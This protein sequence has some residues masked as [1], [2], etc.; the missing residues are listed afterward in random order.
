[1]F[2]LLSLTVTDKDFFRLE[3]QH[4]AVEGRSR[5]GHETY[6][7]VR[8]LGIGLDVGRG[9]D[10]LVPMQHLFV[11]HAHLDHAA[12]IAFWAAQRRLQQLGGG[13]V[14]VPSEAAP[15]FRELLRLQEKLT[16]S[17][18]DVTVV[19]LAAGEELR[20][21]SRHVVRA[22][23][24][25]HRVAARAWEIVEVRHHLLPQYCGLAPAE[26]A[27]LRRHGV[28]VDEEYRRA[29]LFYT[30][31][32]D[33]GLLEQCDEAFRSE[34][35]M[36]ECSFVAEG[37]RERAARYRHIHVDDLADFSDRFEN[38]L[39]VLTHFSRRYSRE[40]ILDT[41]RRRLPASLHARVRLALPPPWQQV[42]G[43]GG[44]GEHGTRNTEHGTLNT[45]H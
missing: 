15:D 8:E 5:A 34:V 3:T 22:H 31:D 35:L 12:G 33:R 30:G 39:I 37:H 36:I 24:A 16:G 11:T 19:G 2:A 40:E 23:P 29:L 25:P 44:G 32:T 9:P 41:V 14:F 7:R 45:E 43:S 28:T 17:E 1:M 10:L 13:T 26:I 27:R 18:F 42:G 21:D 4:F 20:F 38:D 6:F